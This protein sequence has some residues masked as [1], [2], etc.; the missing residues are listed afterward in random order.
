MKPTANGTFA[1]ALVAHLAA[2]GVT[3]FVLCPGSRSGPLAHVLA[4]AASNDP[5]AAAPAIDLHVR[6]DERVAG[7]VALGLAVATGEPIAV[8][9]TSGTAVGNLL[10]AV[11]E[12]HHA[13]VRLVL[14]TADRPFTLRGTGANQATD[15]RDLFGNFV[16][17]SCDVLPPGEGR[18]LDGEAARLV[19]RALAHA[20]GAAPPGHP[21]RDTVGPV[22]LNL[23]FEDPL[24]PD[25]GDWPR[26]RPAVFE[27]PP[28]ETIPSLPDIE[29]GIVIAGHGAGP[30]AATIAASH[31]WPLLAEPTSGARTGPS[32][33]RG[34]AEALAG[35][36]ASTL[37]DDIEFVLV[38]G[39]P[40]LSRVVAN[41]IVEAPRL[42]VARHGARWREA[43][44]HAEVIARDVPFDWVRTKAR[45]VHIED[46]GSW[47]ARW[48]ALGRDPA[49]SLWG[50]R[51][52]ARAVLASV[53]PAG[54]LVV[55]SSGPIRAVD[56]VL[57]AARI[58]DMPRILANR[59][60]AGIDGTVS[61]AVGVAL[62]D[63][64]PVTAFVGDVTFLHDIGGLLVG[65]RE[66]VPDLR[67]VVAN[68]GGG[69]LFSALE[70]ATAPKDRFERVFTTPHGAD[71][72]SLV[73]GYGARHVAVYDADTLAATLAAPLGGIEVVE[74][75]LAHE[76]DGSPPAS[77]YPLWLGRD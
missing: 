1:R 56:A 12:A 64:G 34:Y 23:Q 17:W 13:G 72:A 60:L 36:R 14:L 9:T 32:Y 15:Q 38:I 29:R 7:F 27:V 50:L 65:T 4:E 66:R 70:H 44:V 39:R 75:V 73:A 20:T 45:H 18:D 10:P 26:G 25:H 35:P 63:V 46:S 76:G 67:I 69:T 3:R 48:M 8:V 11:M 62:A 61:A 6:I 37:T 28:E 31:G 21:S 68:D 24:G 2:S 71:L 55:G 53:G 77:G 51:A 49:P 47:L 57:P 42:W 41:L 74:A 16:Q 58:G 52:V 22:Q 30:A 33:V 43:P 19:E 54:V 5:P 59:G 40:T